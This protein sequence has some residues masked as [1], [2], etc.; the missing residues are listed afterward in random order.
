MVDGIGYAGVVGADEL[1]TAGGGSA[2]LLRIC[3][4]PLS[5]VFWR[6]LFRC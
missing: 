4:A 5:S 6:G 1:D 3:L 2:G